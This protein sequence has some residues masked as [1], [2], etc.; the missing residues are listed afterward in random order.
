MVKKLL[1]TRFYRDKLKTQTLGVSNGP[2]Q[3]K[4]ARKFWPLLELLAKIR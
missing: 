2:I 4:S 3:I 1:L